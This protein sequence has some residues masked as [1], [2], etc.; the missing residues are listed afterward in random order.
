MS[1]KFT[2][3]CVYFS[4]GN[5]CNHTVNLQSGDMAGTLRYSGDEKTQT[6]WTKIVAQPGYSIKYRFAKMVPCSCKQG[7]DCQNYVTF[8]LEDSTIPYMT[9][10]YDNK[11]TVTGFSEVQ[12]DRIYLRVSLR[13]N[14]TSINIDLD[15]YSA[16][17]WSCAADEAYCPACTSKTLVCNNPKIGCDSE[18]AMACSGS[19]AETVTLF[20]GFRMNIITL[21][22]TIISLVSVVTVL[23]CLYIRRDRKNLPNRN[24]ATMSERQ[25][26]HLST[27]PNRAWTEADGIV[28]FSTFSPPP[29]YSSLETLS[30][31]KKLKADDEELP[32]SYNDA[33]R[34]LDKYQI[35]D[36]IEHI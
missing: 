5:V 23:V 33:I 32:P 34:N 9:Y 30:N 13:S 21:A 3:V 35:Y 31:Q 7:T 26:R 22:V 2:D 17:Y 28:D 15:L 6:C 20:Q 36:L 18:R 4:D 11:R 10:C 8:Y 16:H 14:L 19:D 25:L 24:A 1:L 29:E 12:T 27:L